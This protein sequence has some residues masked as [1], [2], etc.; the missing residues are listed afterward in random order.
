MK[1]LLALLFSF[2]VA[3]FIPMKHSKNLVSKD[4][5]QT[6][7]DSANIFILTSESA[8]DIRPTIN[9]N[10]RNLR[11]DK[12]LQKLSFKSF[13]CLLES[14][15]SSLKALGVVYAARSHMDSLLRF[16]SYLL[17]DTT[18][19]QLFK[20][21]GSSSPKIKLG[22]ILT[23]TIDGIKQDNANFAKQPEI[24]NIV[25]NFIK[26]YSSYPQSYKPISFP[27]FSMGSDNKGLTDF[28]IYH[29][30]KIR[31]NSR[32]IVKVT[33]AFILDKNLRINVI[34][35]DSTRYSFSYPP[36]FDYWLKEFGRKLNK[37][38]SVLLKLK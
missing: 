15:S 1:V 14:K 9:D 29:D 13:M 24:E 35:K 28:K 7:I 36:K 25:S 8:I 34:E 21:D 12:W 17:S 20:A 37:D 2:F 6:T 31:N 27:Y 38:D 4:D 22:I 10:A 19:V 16:Y 23:K 32:K 3:S 33:S 18:T 30:Y 26:Q 5:C 11:L